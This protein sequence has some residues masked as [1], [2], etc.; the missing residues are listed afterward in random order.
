MKL[1][2]MKEKE[3]QAYPTR[4]LDQESRKYVVPLNRKR[5]T[6]EKLVEPM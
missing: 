6:R 5:A 1:K 2:V 4:L 3:K